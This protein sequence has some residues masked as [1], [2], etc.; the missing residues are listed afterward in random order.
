MVKHGIQDE[1]VLKQ[2][3]KRLREGKYLHSCKNCDAIQQRSIQ[4][5][6]NFRNEHKNTSFYLLCILQYAHL[7]GIKAQIFLGLELRRL[8][9]GLVQKV[10]R[11]SSL[12]VLLVLHFH[13]VLLWEKRR[14]E[15]V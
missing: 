11:M 1:L 8:L 13:H 5:N 7:H 12:A 6:I 3:C 4:N 15:F 9:A 14:V 10:Q 2:N